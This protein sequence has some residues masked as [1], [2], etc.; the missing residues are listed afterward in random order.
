MYLP[1]SM[2]AYMWGLSFET[3]MS[4]NN[5]A[6]FTYAITQTNDAIV[7]PNSLYIVY[8]IS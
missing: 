8:C 5:N 3:D 6:N 1:D 2:E 4:G 7:V